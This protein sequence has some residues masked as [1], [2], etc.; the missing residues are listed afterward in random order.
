MR[1]GLLHYDLGS[2]VNFNTGIASQE[3]LQ[4]LG[5]KM[6]AAMGCAGIL[7]LGGLGAGIASIFNSNQT[8]KVFG[9]LGLVL[10]AGIVLSMCCFLAYSF[11]R[12]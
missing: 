7:N 5:I 6:L 1:D 8:G 2:Q 12:A 10:N 3:S 11:S 9:I 4:N